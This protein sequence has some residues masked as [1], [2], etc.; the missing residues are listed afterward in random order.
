MI[1]GRR[2]C[3]ATRAAIPDL[4]ERRA[5]IA[6]DP[7]AERAIDRRTERALAHA[8][9]CDDCRAAV[10]T[11]LLVDHR[12][13]RYGLAVRRAPVPDPRPPVPRVAGRRDVW[14]WRAGLAGLLAGAAIVALAVG[15]TTALRARPTPLQEVGVEPARIAALRREE[16]R[17][18]AAVLA[19][20]RAIR[21]QPPPAT[22]RADGPRPDPRT[23]ADG[24]PRWPG[25]DG[26]GLDD[27][28]PPTL[29]G[30]SEPRTA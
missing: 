8:R 19:A 20:Q 4:L 16:E 6:V 30:P 25:P 13:R 21:S 12:L 27:S 23:E 29:A 5:G 17:R 7:A 24:T 28:E 26:R 11:A 9:V 14:R 3:R 18:E 10:E 22:R 15:P 1:V 2:A